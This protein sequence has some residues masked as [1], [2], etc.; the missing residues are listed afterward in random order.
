M[1]SSKWLW[2]TLEHSPERLGDP[3]KEILDLLAMD[4]RVEVFR[5]YLEGK[6][7]ERVSRMVSTQASE[8]DRWQAQGAYEAIREIALRLDRD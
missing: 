1:S 6:M 3:E 8:Q 7:W 5:R 2:Q 4:P